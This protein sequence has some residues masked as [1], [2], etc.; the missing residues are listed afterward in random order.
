MAKTMAER[1]D[2]KD[3]DYWETRLTGAC[4]AYGA[5]EQDVDLLTVQTLIEEGRRNGWMPL[6]L[7]PEKCPNPHIRKVMREFV[8]ECQKH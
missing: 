7:D 1:E 4:N 8:Q 3:R 6:F 2:G 5:S